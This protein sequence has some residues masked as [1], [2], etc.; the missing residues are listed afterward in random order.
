MEREP[1]TESAFPQVFSLSWLINWLLSTVGSVEMKRWHV[2]VTWDA[3]GMRW[4][5]VW[6]LS[7][8][9]DMPGTF[10]LP[11]YGALVPWRDR[12]RFPPVH[13]TKPGTAPGSEKLPNIISSILQLLEKNNVSTS[14]FN[15]SY[16]TKIIIH[17]FAS[18]CDNVWAR[19]MRL[20]FLDAVSPSSREEEKPPADPC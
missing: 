7:S 9:L 12:N 6:L 1:T 15:A 11:R 8:K 17:G 4:D 16:T 5:S 14:F 2:M 10:Q 19:K 20:S 18:S 13:T 3:S